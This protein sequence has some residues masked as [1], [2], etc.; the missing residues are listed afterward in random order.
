MIVK[1]ESAI[2]HRQINAYLETGE[3]LQDVIEEEVSAMENRLTE[4]VET[5]QRDKIQQQNT[6]NPNYDNCFKERTRIKRRSRR[7]ERG[8]PSTIGDVH[9]Q[10]IWTLVALSIQLFILP[11]KLATS[12]ET[13]VGKCR[14]A[15]L[16]L[17]Q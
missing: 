6:S 16:V 5:N 3:R 7:R 14:R 8:R 1:Q 17:T 15:L 9:H 4:V 11:T 13:N 10:L 12:L 2:G